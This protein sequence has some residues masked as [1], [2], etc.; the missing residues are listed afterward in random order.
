[1]L[2]FSEYIR[3][4]RVEGLYLGA[5]VKIEKMM[6]A[7][8]LC[9]VKLSGGYALSAEKERYNLT[10]YLALIGDIRHITWMSFGIYKKIDVVGL[11]RMGIGGNSITTLFLKED[12]PDFYDRKGFE[13]TLGEKY[14]SWILTVGGR[15]E[16]NYTLSTATQKSLS[17][18]DDD[19]RSNPPIDEGDLH[20]VFLSLGFDGVEIPGVYPRGHKHEIEVTI[21]GGD[22]LGGDLKFRR[23][24][25]KN[26]FYLRVFWS[27]LLTIHA[28]LGASEDSLPKQDAFYLGGP[29]SLRG[30]P[31]DYYHGNHYWLLRIDHYLPYQP[32]SWLRFNNPFFY[33]FRPNIFADFGSVWTSTDFWSEPDEKI[34]T[35]LGI[36]ISDTDNLFRIDC[37]WPL[38][39]ENPKPRWT[40][41]FN[42]KW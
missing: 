13:I 22:N 17:W 32:L 9:G 29:G 1:M 28:G 7:D 5:G 16:T 24:N 41:Q 10:T 30:H 37:A 31:V 6:G 34:Y 23:I 12:Y 4:N 21:A 19:F 25:F 35:D 38:D 15:F 40:I 18:I 26:S 2:P 42:Y 39:H 3:F 33:A 36:G 27:Q 11:Q 8:V 14:R 20:S